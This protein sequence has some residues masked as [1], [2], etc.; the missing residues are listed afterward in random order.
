V[1]ITRR[2]FLASSAL[3][4]AAPSILRSRLFAMPQQTPA[5]KFEDLHGGVGIF[6]GQ[7]GNIGWLVTPDGALAVDS[8]YPATAQVC[9]D[10]LKQ[11]SPKG[12]QLLINT[13]HHGDHVNGNPA[14]RPVVSK[15]V[16]QEKCA[17][18]H[19]STTA[20]ATQQAYADTTF[21]GS[22]ST[23][24]GG[25]KVWGKFYGPGHTGGDCIVIF[26]KANIVHMG[27][28]MF[29]RM[30]P[31]IDRPNGASIKN[32]VKAVGKIADDH[33]DAT[34]IFGHAKQGTPVSGPRAEL[35]HFRD[36]LSAVLDHAQ[37]GIRAKQ[38]LEEITKVESLPGFEDF[39]SSPPRLTLAAALTTAHQ[40]LTGK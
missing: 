9:V 13:H 38:S 29:N 12:I 28:L 37:K 20:T 36:Y 23:T 25:E 32:W 30:H 1:S 11:R 35:M 39:A 19:K 21:D 16:Q 27:D 15:I 7:G 3:A 34:F 4:V 10:G 26:E 14:F 40:E 24:L 22:W 31:F 17:A 2:Q 18:Y 5:T 33:K 8:Q 6:T